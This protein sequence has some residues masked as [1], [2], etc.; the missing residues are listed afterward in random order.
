MARKPRTMLWLCK[1]TILLLFI[2]F[3]NQPVSVSCETES[4]ESAISYSAYC[5][6]I[7]PESNPYVSSRASTSFGTLRQSEYGA[8]YPVGEN[9]ILN[10]N[11]T[12]L[13]NSFLF[14]TRLVYKTDRDGVFKI[15]SRLAF[16]SP[17]NMPGR[18]PFYLNLQGFWSESSGNLCMVGEGSAYSK[19]GYFHPIVLRNSDNHV[20]LGSSGLKYE[21]TEMERVKKS[22]LR[23]KPDRKKE[24]ISYASAYNSIDMEFGISVKTSEGKTGWGSA[25]PVSV[26]DRLYNRYS[27]NPVRT[28]CFGIVSIFNENERSSGLFHASIELYRQNV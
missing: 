22:C 8:Y 9:R 11:D 10:S 15:E 28:E 25:V 6:K 13:V 24:E 3:F 19:E 16:Q 23:K 18:I 14:R 4:T 21:Y 12:R 5:S 2:S 1:L 27:I 20:E 7:V 26:G 17:G